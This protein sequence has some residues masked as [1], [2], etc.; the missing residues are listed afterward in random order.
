[1]FV[2]AKGVESTEILLKIIIGAFMS[3]VDEVAKYKFREAAIL[4]FES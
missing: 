2:Q 4:S 1:V 3:Q